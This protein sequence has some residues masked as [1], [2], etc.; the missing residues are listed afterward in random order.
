MGTQPRALGL[1]CSVSLATVNRML[2]ALIGSL[3]YLD[4]ANRK[5]DRKIGQN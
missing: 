2:T 4:V 3:Y 1:L 5:I